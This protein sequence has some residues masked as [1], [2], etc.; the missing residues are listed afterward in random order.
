ML[1][2]D[3]RIHVRATETLQD[4]QVLHRYPPGC[5]KDTPDGFTDLADTH[6][7][8]LRIQMLLPDVRD[9]EDNVRS[10]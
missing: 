5:L 1:A 6:R 3:P 4:M 2:D 9:F 7:W 8:G 10:H